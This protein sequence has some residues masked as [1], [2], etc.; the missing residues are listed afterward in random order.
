MDARDE[1]QAFHANRTRGVQGLVL[2]AVEM[3][4]CATKNYCPSHP[5]HIPPDHVTNLV[6]G[7]EI[8]RKGILPLLLKM[9]LKTRNPLPPKQQPPSISTSPAISLYPSPLPCTEPES[10]RNDQI[11]SDS[12]EALAGGQEKERWGIL[13]ARRPHGMVGKHWEQRQILLVHISRGKGKLV[14]K[15]EC[16]T[17]ESTL[18]VAG[19]EAAGQLHL[20]SREL[21]GGLPF[22]KQISEWYPRQ[23]TIHRSSGVCEFADEP[24]TARD[25]KIERRRTHAV[26]SRW[27]M[28]RV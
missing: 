24:A 21:G 16:P 18:A 12:L 5:L 15:R 17:L 11:K 13:L 6:E 25:G 27:M 1:D 8:M 3:P 2:L 19:I 28:G 4:Y 9:V 7:W 22:F 26:R 23:F 14:P 20:P 10:S